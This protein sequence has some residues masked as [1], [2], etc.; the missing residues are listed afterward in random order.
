[1]QSF[2]KNKVIFLFLASFGLA[3]CQGSPT[4]SNVNG[5]QTNI[6]NV[7]VV[8]NVNVVTNTNS[9]NLLAGDN[10]GIEAKEPEQY[11]ATVTLKLETGGAE[12]T[13][14][15]A[16]LSALVSKS[17]ANKRMEFSLP[18]NEK[19]IYLERDGKQFVIAPQRKQYAELNKDSL[20][21]DPRRLLTPEQIVKQVKNIK[22]V[23]RVGEEKFGDRDVIKYRYNATT[24]VN[25][26]PANIQPAANTNTNTPAKVST[27]AVILV[28]KESGLPLRSETFAQSQ[29]SSVSGMNSLR[30][31]TEM[32]NLKMTAD[33]SQFAEP[34]DF[35]KVAPEEI[36]AQMDLVFKTLGMF[37][38]QL[39]S[40][41]NQSSTTTNTTTT[42]NTNTVTP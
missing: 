33:E 15:L 38:Q 36:R 27:D 18:N 1:M 17:G 28:D 35:K 21:T 8:G 41:Q 29:N 24:Q 11:Q 23:E 26:Q 12:K 40:S 42:T 6:S 16:P 34:T 10:T 32:T 39:M 37:L 3:A 5:N 7:P 4:T 31:V 9:N 22:G 30:V 2:S 14:S 19:I 13:A 25:P 20:G